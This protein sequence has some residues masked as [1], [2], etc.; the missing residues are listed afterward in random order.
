MNIALI[1]TNRIRPPIAPIGLEYEAETLQAAGRSVNILDLCWE[2]EI[3][4]NAIRKGFCGA[5]WD[6]LRRIGPHDIKL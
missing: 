1:N 4:V 2:G 3:L 5:Y 6:I